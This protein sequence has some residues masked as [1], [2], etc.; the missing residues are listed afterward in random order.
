[1]FKIEDAQL[2]QATSEVLGQSDRQRDMPVT[3]TQT[4][5]TCFID[6]CVCVFVIMCV[7]LCVC[8]C[9]C[10]FVSVSL[11]KCVNN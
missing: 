7:F 1:M 8:V 9:V 3:H 6:R 5:A 11:C 2:A 10:V 4:D